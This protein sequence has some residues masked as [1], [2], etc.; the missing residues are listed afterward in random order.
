MGLDPL[1]LEH[2]AH[3]AAV[4]ILGLGTKDCF[5]SYSEQQTTS[6]NPDEVDGELK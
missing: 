1:D 6:A 5:G 4:Y 3:S 2:Q